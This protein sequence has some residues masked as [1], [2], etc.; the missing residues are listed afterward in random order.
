M[1]G[2]GFIISK[3]NTEI[4]MA[5]STWSRLA[6]C[7]AL[8]LSGRLSVHVDLVL[9]Y[10]AKLHFGFPNNSWSTLTLMDSKSYQS[11][12]FSYFTIFILINRRSTFEPHNVVCVRQIWV[13]KWCCICLWSK[14]YRSTCHTTRIQRYFCVNKNAR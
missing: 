12:L 11:A 7:G 5:M 3:R 1:V 6:C 14:F 4:D 8:S 10:V 9:F 2:C 13:S